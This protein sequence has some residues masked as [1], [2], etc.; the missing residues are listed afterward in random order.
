[1]DLNLK[2]L[3]YLTG[4]GLI[5]WYIGVRLRVYIGVK[6]YSDYLTGFWLILW[7]I[8]LGLEN[9][10]DSNKFYLQSW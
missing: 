6:K 9:H 5:S 7:Y 1:M 10:L 8:G 2:Y 3:S 4:L